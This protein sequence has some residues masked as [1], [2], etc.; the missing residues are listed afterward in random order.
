MVSLIRRSLKG[1][2]LLSFSVLVG[3]ALAMAQTGGCASGNCP[4]GA[5]L[6]SPDSVQQMQNFLPPGQKQKKEEE[7]DFFSDQKRGW[8][9]YEKEPVKPEKAEEKEESRIRI[10]IDLD[11]YTDQDL[12]NMYPD[13]FQKLL[14]IVLKQAV[15]EPSV[16]NVKDYLTMQDISKR[17][18]MVFANVVG[19]VGQMNPDFSVNEVYPATAPGKR[20]LTAMQ[21]DEKNNIIR[22]SRS[23]YA[24]IMFSQAE[25]RFCQ[26]QSEILA[27]F[28]DY[29]DWPVRN[30]DTNRQPNIATRFNVEKVPQIIIVSKETGDY[31]PVSVGVISMNE[32]KDR[33]YRSIRMM[34]GKINPEQ[35]YIH[36]FEKNT[37][38]DPL[39]VVDRNIKNPDSRSLDQ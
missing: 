8:W 25:C 3:H 23:R 39:K 6:N 4:T 13:D 12:W 17:K 30:I 1:L 14:K 2:L 31:M 19:Y 27:Y 37:S 9:W 7:K 10:G 15:Q 32:L 26:S 20:A 16:K 33:I 34:E 5:I 21:L 11:N 22:E 35:W 28:E 24:L 18:S 29:F 36:D 38:M